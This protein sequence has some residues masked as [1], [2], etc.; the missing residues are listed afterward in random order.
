MDRRPILLGI[1]LLQA[2][3][4]V[5]AANIIRTTVCDILVAITDTMMTIGPTMVI[6]MFTYG[7][8]K[9][10]YGGTD[11]GA[12]KSG[13]MICIHSL[14]GGILLSLALPLA[15]PGGALGLTTDCAIYV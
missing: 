10:T 7:G 12:R 15:A 2:I 11:P 14:I 6:L 9:Y 4:N 8:V 3:L 13:K 1:I 5:S